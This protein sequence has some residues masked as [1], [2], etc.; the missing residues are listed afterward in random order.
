MRIDVINGPNLNLLG[1]RETELYGSTSLD[2][3]ESHLGSLAERLGGV[4]VSI[5]MSFFQSNH[6]GALIDRIQEKTQA[7]VDAFI[8]N[9]GGYTH[10]SVALRDAV[11]GSDAM[12]IEL[13]LTNIYA[14]EDFRQ[15]S[16]IADVVDG[17]VTGLGPIGYELALRAAVAVQGRQ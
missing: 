8:L 10:T 9:P 14:R 4:D 15:R 17:H 12:F 16:L 3:I 1:T 11:I 6:E 7:G 13:H 2:S 5:E